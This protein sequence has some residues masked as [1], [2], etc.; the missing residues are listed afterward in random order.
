MKY[1]VVIA[2]A[3]LFSLSAFF[4]KTNAQEGRLDLTVSPPVIELT[5]KPGDIVRE[6]FRVRNNLDTSVNLSISA[7]RLTSDPT[8]GNPVPESEANGEELKWVTFDKPEFT[9]RPSEWEDVTF[10][11]EV[12]EDAAYGYYY[13]FKITPKESTELD[14]TGAQV[15]GELLVV[16][17]LNVQKEGAT[18]KTELVSFSADKM[19]NEY[20]PVNFAVKLANRGNVHVKPRGNIFITRGGGKEISILE[21]N[22]GSGSILPGGTREFEAIWNDGFIEREV[23]VED[24]ETK[25]DA[26]GNPVTKLKFNWNKLTSFRMG[27]YEAKLLMV[28]DDGVK[29]VTIEGTATFWVI[30]YMAIG[31]TLLILIVVFVI[32]KFVLG[33]YIK[34]QIA[35]SKR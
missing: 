17:L 3:F 34:S 6:R 28:Y 19:I 4:V 26:Q 15:K 9:A 25:V 12:P 32:L 5:A 11:I 24:G 30:P 10:T 7:R 21:V 29:D 2:L 20:L 16:T 13:V 1:K 18:S 22:P 35:K 27:P 31:F 23:V 33:M 14:S 8:D